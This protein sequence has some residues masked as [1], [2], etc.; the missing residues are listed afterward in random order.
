MRIAI[1]IVAL[2]GLCAVVSAVTGPVPAAAATVAPSEALIEQARK[3]CFEGRW[4]IVQNRFDEAASRLELALNLV[5][6]YPE[7][8]DLLAQVR[9]KLAEVDKRCEKAAALAG[10]AKWDDA[11]QEIQWG[12]MTYPGSARAKTLLADVKRQAAEATVKS[13]SVLAAAGRLAAAEAEFRK[14]LEYAPDQTPAREAIARIDADRGRQA[15]T[16]GRPGAAY[17][18]LAEAAD[19]APKNAEYQAQAAAARAAAVQ[20]LRFSVIQDRPQGGAGASDFSDAAWRHAATAKPEFMAIV[21]PPPA[22]G[23][24]AAAF[25]VAV[26]LAAVDVKTAPARTENRT[27]AYKANVESPNPDYT[28]LAD[29]FKAASDN[30]AVMQASD[31]QP[32]AFCGGAG[33]SRCVVC[34]G[35]GVR[36]APGAKGGAQPCPYCGGRGVGVCPYCGGRGYGN[37]SLENDIVRA[38]RELTAMQAALSRIAPTVTKQVAADYPYTLTITEKNGTLDSS[39]R[40]TAGGAAVVTEP[41]RKTR[42]FESSAISAPRPDIGLTDTSR[43]L[44]TDDE[45]RRVLAEEGAS[46]AGGKIL[47]AVLGARAAALQAT[48]QKALEEGQPAAAVEMG[49]DASIIKESLNKAEATRLQGVLRDQ[50]RI[51]EKNAEAAKT[52]APDKK[53]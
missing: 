32:C 42:R 9:V 39:V 37:I 34:G 8:K 6:D 28:R 30:L 43:P 13:G 7:A 46:V 51:E 17:L 18:W 1:L 15:M 40:V 50:M 10:Q 26:D 2:G 48:S 11:V 20:R 5:P 25:A 47:S 38:Q 16:L 23:A 12:L 53:P 52:P 3:A 41:V 22:A 44:P 4:F 31:R 27:F 36:I 14:S 29:Q 49:A 21:P 24:G 33:L 35:S 45:V 19:L